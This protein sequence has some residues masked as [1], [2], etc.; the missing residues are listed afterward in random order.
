MAVNNCTQ[1]G[2]HS[3]HAHQLYNQC[4]IVNNHKSAMFSYLCLAVGEGIDS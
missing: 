4:H 1:C 3:M 2:V